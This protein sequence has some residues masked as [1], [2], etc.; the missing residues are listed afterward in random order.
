MS[1]L[2]PTKK[3]SDVASYVKR[4]FG[5]ESGVQIIDDDIVRWVNA[6]QAEI[7][8]TNNV[9]QSSATKMTVANTY[10]YNLGVDM[11]IESIRSVHCDG[12]KLKFLNFNDYETFISAEDPD[13]VQRAR[14]ETWSEWGGVLHLY[15]VPDGVYTLT[16]YYQAAPAIVSALT[17][18]LTIPDRYFQRT[19]DYVLAQ[20]FELDENFNAHSAKM[21]V[22]DSKLVSM[23]LDE[24]KGSTD[25]YPRITITDEDYY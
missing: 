20:A 16:V 5:D 10:Q 21:D 18:T 11:P 17:D 2:A 7:A 14:P 25:T 24:S 23:A 3:V 19:V 9:L 1:W 22:F 8:N 4:Q 15:P 13:M 12:R 6:A